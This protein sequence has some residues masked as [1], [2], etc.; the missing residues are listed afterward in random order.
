MIRNLLRRLFR[1]HRP[2]PPPPDVTLTTREERND[3]T[4]RTFEIRARMERLRLEA[5]RPALRRMHE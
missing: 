2:T 3:I 5:E 4:A 1:P